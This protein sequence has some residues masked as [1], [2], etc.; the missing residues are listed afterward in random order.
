MQ[1]PLHIAVLMGGTSSE[2]EVSFMSG[3]AIEKALRESGHIVER[4]E[5]N[6]EDLREMPDPAGFDPSNPNWP[7]EPT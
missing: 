7:T 1:R 2:R 3:G 6:G 4:I 5:I